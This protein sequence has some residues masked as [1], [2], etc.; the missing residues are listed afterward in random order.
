MSTFRMGLIKPSIYP[1]TEWFLLR[2][3]ARNSHFLRLSFPKLY[4]WLAKHCAILRTNE[5]NH[6]LLTVN[7]DWCI[8]RYPSVIGLNVLVLQ[9]AIEDHSKLSFYDQ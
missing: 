4:D 8:T 3:A 9:H 5:T 7:S 2:D 1:Q 6:N